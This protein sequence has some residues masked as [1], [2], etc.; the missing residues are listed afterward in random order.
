MGTR[1]S[2]R[3]RQ[4]T[5]REAVQL[6]E[7]CTL[8]SLN[9]FHSLQHETDDFRDP[10][11]YRKSPYHKHI[12]S[13]AEE[14]SSATAS[15]TSGC[16]PVSCYDGDEGDLQLFEDLDEAVLSASAYAVPGQRH[17]SR[18][19]EAS[20][21]TSKPAKQSGP[22]SKVHPPLRPARVGLTKA[23]SS[24]LGKGQSVLCFT[25]ATNRSKAAD[26]ADSLEPRFVD[27]MPPERIRPESRDVADTLQPRV[28]DELP[29]GRP[30]SG[31]TDIAGTLEP[32]FMDDLRP[33]TIVL[34]DSSED[35]EPVFAFDPHRKSG[36]R[37]TGGTPVSAG[38]RPQ[39]ADERPFSAAHHDRDTDHRPIS[40]AHW[41]Q[42]NDHRPFSSAHRP[43][44]EDYRPFSAIRDDRAT[45]D[46][47]F[48]AAHRP[49]AHRQPFLSPRSSGPMP[50]SEPASSQPWSRSS[51]PVG[52]S[53]PAFRAQT[54][55][56]GQ[57]QLASGIAERSPLSRTQQPNWAS[58][59]PRRSITS[60]HSSRGKPFQWSSPF[61]ENNRNAA[62]SMRGSAMHYGTRNSVFSNSTRSGSHA[63]SRIPWSRTSRSS[64]NARPATANR[65]NVPQFSPEP[66]S[67]SMGAV[68]SQ[69]AYQSSF[70]P[71]QA[72]AEARYGITRLP[73]DAEVTVLQG[74]G[75][76]KRLTLYKPP[77]L[78][79]TW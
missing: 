40:S 16:D 57:S 24:T 47:P 8:T 53:P 69:S 52:A 64:F 45:D 20:S 1:P 12:A 31:A 10:S 18:S 2:Q 70:Q 15:E 25:P 44:F 37:I 6:T 74:S 63:R 51:T 17:G 14:Y 46:R 54:P 38:H 39:L 4:L 3:D 48:S 66:S 43:Q 5:I 71:T 36:G 78:P 79:G 61:K 9:A 56:F 72:G 29:P 60:S 27:E 35:E 73:S 77:P 13:P 58:E 50:W 30:R 55:S 42:T 34:S 23:S 62:S 41:Q 67:S 21:R 28:M 59:L 49:F 76:K 75:G 32:R 65:F 11:G 19:V 22:S 7:P 26:V 68:S 33:D